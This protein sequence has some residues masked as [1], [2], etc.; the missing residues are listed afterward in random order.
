MKLIGISTLP[1]FK[2]SSLKCLRGLGAASGGTANI[3]LANIAKADRALGILLSLMLI[4]FASTSKAKAEGPWLPLESE[5]NLFSAYVFETFDRFWKA[6]EKQDLPFGELDQHTWSF[7]GSYGILDSLAFDFTLGYTKTDGGEVGR[8]EGLN[9]S[10]LALRYRVIDEFEH[11]DSWYIPTLTLK[12]GA[13]IPGSYDEQDFPIAPGKGA[14][15]ADLGLTLGKIIGS[16]GF[17]ILSSLAVRLYE[18]SVPEQLNANAGIF[19]TF[20]DQLTLSTEYRREQSLSGVDLGSP[21]FVPDLSPQL[22]EVS[23]K[24]EFGIGYTD[25]DS[26]L[27]LGVFYSLTLDGRNTGDKDVFGL[28]LSANAPFLD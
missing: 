24:L 26:E 14:S 7:G 23:D 10:N 9:D 17:G 1:A 28:S 27:Y 13:I 15:G 21:A 22:K 5:T 19:K 2:K 18:G 6:K 16:S 4:L 20:H 12:A 8:T 25:P 3:G 11:L